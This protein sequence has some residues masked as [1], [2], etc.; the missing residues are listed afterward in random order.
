[1]RK[2]SHS[3]LVLIFLFLG[4][5][6]SGFSQNKEIPLW[7]KIPDA[8][9]VVDYKEET[10]QDKEGV[11]NG[12]LKVSQ[13]TLSVFLS[14]SKIANGTSVI[15]C[16]GGGYHHLSINKEGYKIAKWL[17]TLGISAFVL[18]YR[19]PSD[20]IM[21][22]KS[23]GPLQDAQEAVRIVRRN[24]EKW[25]LDPDKIGII[26]F[27]AG[28]HLAST[29]ATKFDEKVY[30]SKDNTSARPD[31]SILIY[32]VISMQDG[33]TH[34]GSKTNLLGENPS[35]EMGDKYSNEKQVNVTTPKTF[36]VH[37][38]DDKSVP[39]ENSINY[40]LALKQNKIPVEMHIYENGGHG[41]GLGVEGTNKTWTKACENWLIANKFIP[42]VSVKK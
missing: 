12:V 1:M 30:I 21:K 23:I 28:G 8:I 11:I 7:D 2:N 38:T 6:I 25:K 10:T 24:A 42:N 3:Q 16:P 33:I 31:F 15:I 14:D 17:N 41:F 35:L 32:P 18:K 36:I 27:S 26:G 5:G 4:I 9:D 22:D 13:P 19:L 29:L 34:K 40:Y 20:L 39:V 37:A